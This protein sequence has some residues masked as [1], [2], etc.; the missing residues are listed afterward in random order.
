MEI[1]KLSLFYSY[2]IQLAFCVLLTIRHLYVLNI[3]KP[4]I[5]A[6]YLANW[7]VLILGIWVTIFYG[8]HIA[9]EHGI[10]DKIIPLSIIIHGIFIIPLLQMRPYRHTTLSLIL[11]MEVI[12]IMFIMFAMYIRYIKY[13]KD[14]IYRIY[15]GA[16]ILKY[17]YIILLGVGIYM[18]I[19]WNHN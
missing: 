13:R 4:L 10:S 19:K 2:W 9:Q 16:P 6:I 15:G 1:S 17:I 8:K 14:N 12:L 11:I 7:I 18:Y 5:L 3:D